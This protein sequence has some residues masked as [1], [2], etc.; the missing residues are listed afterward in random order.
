MIITKKKSKL[1]LTTIILTIIHMS[2]LL[3]AALALVFNIFGIV[4]I[5]NKIL[6]DYLEAGVTIDYY[7]AL[8]RNGKA[9][10]MLL[11][12]WKA[13]CSMHII[14]TKAKPGASWN[15]LHPMSPA[16]SISMVGCTT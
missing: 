9:V 8:K 14:M 12:F 6:Q 11:Y 15:C 3:L 5:M 1:L 4:D 16:L 2:L 7:L 13:A 10:K